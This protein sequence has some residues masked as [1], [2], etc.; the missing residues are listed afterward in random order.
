MRNFL[1]CFCLALLLMCVSAG[2]ALAND[3]DVNL[4]T[5]CFTNGECVLSQGDPGLPA[6]GSADFL[7]TPWTYQFLTAAPISWHSTMFHYSA[8]FGPG[9]TFAMTGP[10]NLFFV[11]Q[12]TSGSEYAN[13][14]ETYTFETDLNFTGMW[15]NN[16]EASGAI[17]IG[18]IVSSVTYAT[19]DTYT[20]PEPGSLVLLGSG[21]MGVWGICRRRLGA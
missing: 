7:G 18:G 21:V 12:I 4:T 14:N 13:Y 8:V 9:G 17:T 1:R 15:S 6:M 20:V 11:G 2:S 16:V 19:L 10:D 5:D 3:L